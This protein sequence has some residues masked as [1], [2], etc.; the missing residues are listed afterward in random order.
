MQMSVASQ[1]SELSD[2][3]VSLGL[4]GSVWAGSE[5]YPGGVSVVTV[6]SQFAQLCISAFSFRFKYMTPWL[7][8]MWLV[9]GSCVSSVLRLARA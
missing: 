8:G 9:A 1:S 7:A 6:P 3:F 2:R 4:M 5:G